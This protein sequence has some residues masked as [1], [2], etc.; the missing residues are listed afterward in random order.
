[1]KIRLRRSRKLAGGL[2]L[3]LAL[4][5]MVSLAVPALAVEQ[6]PHQFFGS[7]TVCGTP[8]VEEGTVVSALI[9]GI[10]YPGSTTQVDNLDRYGWDPLFKLPAD[11]TEP[12]KTGG[13]NGD[14]VEFYVHLN[15]VPRLAG[16]AVFQIDGF[17]ELPLN[18]TEVILTTNAD[19]AEGGTV[20]GAGTYDCSTIVDVEAIPED[21]W[22]FTEWSGD[23]GGDTNP[24]TIHMDDDKTVTANFAP[25]GPTYELTVNANPPEGGEVTGEGAYPYDTYAAITATPNECY[26]FVNWTGEGI[27]DPNS[28]STTVLVDE[29]KTVTANFTLLEYDLTVNANPLE[30]GEVTGSGTYDC[31]T[32]QPITAT[33]ADTWYFVNWTGEGIA[34]PN[35]AETTVHID[36]DKTVTANFA[37]IG[38]TYLTVNTT[39][40]GTVTDPGVGTYP[41]DT[42]TVVPLVAEPECGFTFVNWTG[43]VD[44]VDDFTAADTTIQMNADYEITANFVSAVIMEID[45][46]E[47]WN[48]FSTP[49]ALDPC[50]NTWDELVALSG[51]EDN[52]EMIYFYYN[53]GTTQQWGPVFTGYHDDVKPLEG[54]F[55][56][57]KSEGTVRIVPN[58]GFTPPPAKEL[59]AGLNLIGPASL[60]NRD[61]VSSL[62]DVYEVTGDLTGYSRVL[63][64][65]I[66]VPNDFV[67]D[68]YV[69][70]DPV[71]PTMVVG[72]AYWVIMVNPG[73]LYGYTSTPLTP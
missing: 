36:G 37:E 50:C 10:E 58:P 28:A 62:V 31:C 3:L 65:S 64:P 22:G 47:G 15:G 40:G 55:V 39:P 34:E 63:N 35:S 9:G 25:I 23:L 61:I 69:R 6:Q 2:G 38:E 14:P 54:F 5:L 32:Y 45:L 1:M 12:G 71:I 70:D 53:D 42:G 17:T 19:P 8:A 27:T 56:K 18:V 73:T 72:K 11:D 26:E 67:D 52:V 41:Y 21:G 44:T 60:V 59:F 7:V 4:A 13:V 57:M 29:D 66:N 49:I 16:T 24:T 30:G 20:T 46:V 33:P 43:D 68:A 51:L 48:T